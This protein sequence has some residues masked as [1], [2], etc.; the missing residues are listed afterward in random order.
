MA[1][2]DPIWKITDPKSVVPHL[3][4]RT[5]WS[6]TGAGIDT[7]ETPEAEIGVLENRYRVS[8]PHDFREYLKL[9]AP[10]EE[11]WDAEDGNWWPVGRIKNIPD[12][13]DHPVSEAIMRNAPKHLIFLDYSIWSWAWAISCA[14]DETRGR[15]AVIG[16]L[17]DGYVADSFGEFVERYTTDWMSIR[18]VQAK[19]K[20]RR[21]FW[22]WLGRS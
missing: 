9:G 6:E 10:K 20:P 15:V 11:N 1:D 12:E 22:S 16:G 21:G 14:D 13:Y 3:T 5:W 7:R 8:L 18:Q 19:P 17:P 2:I 4:L